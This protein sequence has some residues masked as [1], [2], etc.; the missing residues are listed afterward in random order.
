MST[1]TKAMADELRPS[2]KPLS[3]LTKTEA[4]EW[5]RSLGEEPRVAWT[6][7][8]IKSRIKEILDLLAEEDDNLPKNLTGMPKTD[9]QRECTERH[10]HFTEHETRGSLM[11]KIRE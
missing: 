3:A 8:E 2:S 10:I 6:S 5:L 1:V 4:S 9:L 7:V 11:R